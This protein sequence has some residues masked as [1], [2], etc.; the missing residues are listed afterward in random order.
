VQDRG[1]HEFGVLCA[2]VAN[3]VSWMSTVDV[4]P[5]VQQPHRLLPCTPDD[6]HCFHFPFPARQG[7]AARG[8][9]LMRFTPH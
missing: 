3:S 6:L 4:W 5:L 8:L 9:L 7:K 2:L 1:L